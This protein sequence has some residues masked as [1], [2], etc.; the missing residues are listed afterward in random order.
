VDLDAFILIGGRS[1]RFGR[2]KAFVELDGELLANRAARIVRE[3]LHPANVRYLAAS[4]GQ[5][6]QQVQS[7]HGTVVVDRR[8]GFGGWSALDGALALS[9]AEWTFVMA[10]DLPFVDADL[11]ERMAGTASDETDAVVPKQSDGRLQPLCAIYRTENLRRI[12]EPLVEQA[13]PL[14]PLGT[15]F[16]RVPTAIIEADEAVLRNVN[17][18]TDLDQLRAQAPERVK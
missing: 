11:L 15:V 16:D 14:P 1:T 4:N 10:C 7:L 12:A 5:F 9:T 2:D 6:G 3:S 18:A 17:Y 8:P 13:G